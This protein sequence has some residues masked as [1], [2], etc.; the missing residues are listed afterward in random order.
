[1]TNLVEQQ[2]EHF[3]RISSQY[4]A[5]RNNANHLLLKQ[6]LWR[7]FLKRHPYLKEQVNRV[8]EP[9]CGTAEGYEILRSNLS[10]DFSY[11]GF[12]YSESM[13]DFARSQHPKLNIIHGDVTTFEPDGEPYDIIFLIGGLHHVFSRTSDVLKNLGR[14]LRPNGYFLSFEPTHNNWIARRVRQSIYKSNNLFDADTEQ[15]FEYYGLDNHF[16][17]AG[18]EKVDDVYAGL[19]A[20][21]L[22]YNPDAFPMLNVGGSALVRATFAIDR[23]L[24]TNWIGRKLSFATISLW[25]RR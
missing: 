20:Y 18:F 22:Y 13:V 10:K 2:R 7:Y 24:W 16:T 4:F 1:M 8:L 9:M 6:L 5:A 14:A 15:G 21:I 25:Q 11:L 17:D 23:L 12:D 19:L 3:N